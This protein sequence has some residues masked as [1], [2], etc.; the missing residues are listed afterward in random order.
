MATCIRKV[1]SE[2]WSNQREWMAELKTLE[3]RWWNKEVQRLVEEKKQCYR[4][5]YHDRNMDN[6]KKYTV[7]KK[8]ARQAVSVI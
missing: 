2:M 4:C 3:S 7:V 1:A 6:T 5:M 8:T